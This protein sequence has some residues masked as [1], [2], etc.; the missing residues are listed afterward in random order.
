APRA[1]DHAPTGCPRPPPPRARGGGPEVGAPTAESFPAPY[2]QERRPRRDWRATRAMPP[3]SIPPPL[4]VRCPWSI[5]LTCIL[6][7]GSKRMNRLFT[8][9]AMVACAGLVQADMITNQVD[10]QIDGEPFQ[11]ALV[12]DDAISEPRP[13]LLM[14]PNWMG[15]TDN[16]AKKASRVAGSDYVVFVADMY[17]SDIR[18]A[19]AKEAGAAAGLVKGDRALM[20]QRANAALEVFRREAAGLIDT[21]RLG[22]VGFCF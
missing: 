15:V 19:D 7:T 6:A 12:F 20:R 4:R 11:G 5:L 17:G 22:A 16:A 9:L 2:W 18:P 10:Y 1:N 8:A 3:T 13:G 21:S 14:V